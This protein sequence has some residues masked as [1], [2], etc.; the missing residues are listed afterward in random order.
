[1]LIREAT[2]AD[3]PQIARVHV[4][5]WRTTYAGT[6]PADF[7]EGMSYEDFEVRWR[8]WMSESGGYGIFYVAEL[9][10]DQIIGF[11]SGGPRR[12]GQY[13]EYEGELYAAYLLRDYQHRG[14]G[15]WLIDAVAE[16]LAAE[17]K[18]SM[19]AWV[20]A[21]NPSRPFY[22][23]LGGKLLGSQDIEIGGV[24][25]NEVAYGWDDT[26]NLTAFVR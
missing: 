14:L 26:R 5:S 3:V 4:D 7:L 23:A 11:A 17:G 10:P 24:T 2:A 22:E 21:E 12:E 19:L 25:L 20:R 8:G 15:R 9:P 1:M 13:P 6:V 16:G 18:R